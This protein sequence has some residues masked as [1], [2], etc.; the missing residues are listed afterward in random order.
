MKRPKRRKTVARAPKNIHLVPPDPAS[1][2]VERCARCATTLGDYDRIQNPA[3]VGDSKSEKVCSA[4][5][6]SIWDSPVR[7]VIHH[8]T[9][10][11]AQELLNR[12]ILRRT[13]HWFQNVADIP[14][15]IFHRRETETLRWHWTWC[16]G[17]E[18]DKE[19]RPAYS[20]R[21]WCGYSGIV[22]IADETETCESLEWLL[23]H[24]LG[25][26]EQ[27]R[28]SRMSDQAWGIENRTEGR[29]GYEWQDDAG[30]E[31]DSEERHVNRV[32]TAYM[33]GREMARPWWRPR[34]TA[35]LRGDRVLP[36]CWAPIESQEFSAA[37]VL[38]AD[39]FQGKAARARYE[40]EVNPQS[41]A[42]TPVS[43]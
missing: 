14:V 29:N 7:L 40:A 13:S 22:L 38:P 20:F 42:S 18:P 6:L 15:H 9:P 28:Q 5:Y 43:L 36:D 37:F 8:G 25:H 35:K 1:E 34:V 10:A 16:G 27:Q 21:G 39:S 23:Y 19:P 30:H 31:A 32:A 3:I 4:C 24:E 11:F 33:R 26:A 17:M 2:D 12:E 41:T